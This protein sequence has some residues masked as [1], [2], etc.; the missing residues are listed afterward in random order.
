MLWLMPWLSIGNEA[1][2]LQYQVQPMF[3]TF[4]KGK[5]FYLAGSIAAIEEAC[6]RW[7]LWVVPACCSSADLIA[8][9]AEA[10]IRLERIQICKDAFW[11]ECAKE[12]GVK[13]VHLGDCYG[14]GCW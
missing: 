5:A 3:V 1:F 4:S 8:K 12:D 2:W 11:D 14:C 6:G 9:E 13:L 7:M 10:A